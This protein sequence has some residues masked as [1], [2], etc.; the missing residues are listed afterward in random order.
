MRRSPWLGRLLLKDSVLRAGQS[1]TRSTD[2]GVTNGIATGSLLVR[3]NLLL[4]LLLSR[5]VLIV[6]YCLLLLLDNSLLL[7]LSLGLD[8]LLSMLLREVSLC[9]LGSITLGTGSL[10]C[11]L[12]LLVET[13]KSRIVLSCWL[14]CRG[15]SRATLLRGDAALVVCAHWSLG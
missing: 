14:R 1:R 8:L 13:G 7:L 2:G 4:H 10:T 3:H 12:C 15:W 9:A 6:C 5:L 11:L